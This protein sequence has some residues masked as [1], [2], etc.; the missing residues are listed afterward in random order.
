[1]AQGSGY[2]VNACKK[3]FHKR[4]SEFEPFY[5]TVEVGSKILKEPAYDITEFDAR[6]VVALLSQIV[7][8]RGQFQKDNVFHFYV[9]NHDGMKE[10]FKLIA[11]PTQDQPGNGLVF[12]FSTKTLDSHAPKHSDLNLAL[13]HHYKNDTKSF[14]SDMKK[15]F[16]NN[17]AVNEAGFPQVTI[18]AYVV[19]LFEIA[20]RLVA[21]GEDS[22]DTKMQF[23]DLP[24]GSAIA[25][26]LELLE[27]GSEEICTF[28]D[29][30]STQ[31]R[32]HCFAGKP[33]ERR[34][35]IDRMN[36]TLHLQELSKLFCSNEEQ[37]DELNELAEALPGGLNL[38]D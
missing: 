17:A 31:G 13:K 5:V 3:F 28:E 15:L 18:E 30:F 38:K 21:S 12:P 20:R 2:Q 26:L 6:K 37:V 36:K 22:T 33:E 1:M 34:E 25:R 27:L 4:H 23:D 29:V 14:A 7:N 8:D 19:L 9:D 10:L 11:R 32:F 24:I 16:R 35:A